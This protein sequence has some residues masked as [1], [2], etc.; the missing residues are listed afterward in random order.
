MFKDT[1]FWTKPTHWASA[2]PLNALCWS[3]SMAIC[4][5]FDAQHGHLFLP[6]HSHNG[7]LP[8]SVLV[9]GSWELE[10]NHVFHDS[11][12]TDL[13]FMTTQINGFDWQSVVYYSRDW[14]HDLILWSLQKTTVTG[15][16]SDHSWSSVSTCYPLSTPWALQFSSTVNDHGNIWKNHILVNREF[17]V[18]K[19]LRGC[20]WLEVL[21]IE[22]QGSS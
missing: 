18:M 1:C 9:A 19:I 12:P 10:S 3:L 21:W 15:N 4:V 6:W 22:D 11:L 14:L 2:Q 8:V 5:C 16:E 7:S 20:D 17:T 13:D